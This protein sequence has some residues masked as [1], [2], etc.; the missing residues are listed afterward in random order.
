VSAY[1]EFVAAEGSYGLL[2]GEEFVKAFFD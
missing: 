1:D 2:K